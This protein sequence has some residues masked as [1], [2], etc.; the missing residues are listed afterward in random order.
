M[1][2]LHVE[3]HVRVHS[4][5]LD[6]G[7]FQRREASLV[8]VAEIEPSRQRTQQADVRS[9]SSGETV[10]ARWDE[11]R[12]GAHRGRRRRRGV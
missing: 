7:R 9:A 10:Q 1:R 6:D 2:S 5:C 4:A 12:L 11:V 3:T 8:C